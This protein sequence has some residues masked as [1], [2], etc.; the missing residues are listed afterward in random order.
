MSPA[1]HESGILPTEFL[2]AERATEAELL[3][4][5]MVFENAPFARKLIDAGLGFAMVLNQHR[6]IIH[7]NDSFA[8]YLHQRGASLTIGQRPGEAIGCVH[9]AESVG[10]CGTTDGCRY[11]GAAHIVATGLRGHTRVAECRI[12]TLESGDDLE[13]LV[14]ITP[15]DIHGETFLIFS[16]VDV[17]D[18]KRRVALERVFFHDIANTAGG[19]NGLAR[20]IHATPTEVTT[21]KYAPLLEAASDSLIDEIA[22]HRELACAERGDL[23]ARPSLFR[24][25]PLLHELAGLCVAHAAGRGRHVELASASENLL[26]HSDRV[27]LMR[28][29]VNLI[30]NALEA[31]PAGST[32][33]V[34]VVR[35]GPEVVFSVHN[36]SVMPHDVQMQI[37]Q[38]SFST[39]GAGRGLGTYSIRLLTERYLCGSVSF[40][41]TPDV[42]TLFHVR[43]PRVL[44][45]SPF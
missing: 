20:L 22:S 7:V 43:C 42:G 23:H 4:Q 38:R 44:G 45:S 11:C 41:S 39:K 2:P 18:E 10:G 13:L 24:V 14:R 33:T 25:A 28:V 6:Q 19:I 26:I 29:L 37:F 32:V 27:L 1:T 3:R 36:P 31:E 35:E 12:Q 16:A 15:L 30:K 17:S 21:R 8:D 5:I 9:G 34:G 40:E